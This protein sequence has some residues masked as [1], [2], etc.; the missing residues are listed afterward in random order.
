MKLIKRL[1]FLSIILFFLMGIGLLIFLETFDISRF[2]PQIVEQLNS[3]L[4][5]NVTLGDM[6]LSF[7]WSRGLNVGVK[8]L[9]IS[10]DPNFSDK[11]FLEVDSISLGIEI[12]PLITKRQIF[13]ASVDIE[14]PK[15]RLIRD[16]NGLL[17]AQTLGRQPQG[18]EA[19]SSL[20][21]FSAAVNAQA[22]SVGVS[23]GNVPTPS[24]SKNFSQ[25]SSQ[26]S[27][28]DFSI[29]SIR[30]RN[31]FLSYQ[32][33][34]VQPPISVDLPQM[35]VRIDRFT[36][37]KP[38]PV[39][40]KM[41]LWS[42]IPN[43]FVRGN[44]I[45][46]LKAGS[47]IYADQV[48]CT[49]DFSRILVEKIEQDL[50][51]VK[52]AG[53][54]NPLQGHLAIDIH[55]MKATQEGLID[56]AGDG[57]FSDGRIRLKPLAVPVEGIQLTFAFDE[58]DFIVNNFSLALGSGAV[59]GRFT[60]ED[61]LKEQGYEFKFLAEKVQIGE[62]I[63][64]KALPFKAV[65]KIEGRFEGKGQGFDPSKAL[66]SLTAGGQFNLFEGRLVDFNVLKFILEKITMIPNLVEKLERNLPDEYKAMLN[67]SD[68]IISNAQ[69]KT[70][71]YKG[72][73][74][75]PEAVVE[76]EGIKFSAQG[77]MTFEQKLKLNSSVVFE[78]SLSKAM[79]DSI[80][81]LKYF[82][83]D[84]NQI[85]IPLIPYDGEATKLVV[86]PDPEYLLK[87]FVKTK[88]RDELK[89]MIS[90]AMGREEDTAQ[91]PA[92]QDDQGNEEKSTEG[93]LLDNLL[94]SIF[95]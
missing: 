84:E 90:K 81:E 86:Y 30:I 20:E 24:D 40:F 15:I 62:I 7:S 91:Q 10:D 47:V 16:K 95:K 75:I 19:N 79:T 76:L 53:L 2:K 49:I 36:V 1:F 89:K 51:V 71:I 34:M 92:D 70:Q 59:S 56:L 58:K 87:K 28:P 46:E 63:G 74:H 72:S 73:V 33:T 69:L 61:Y 80:E 60:L 45:V 78:E 26:V 54:I 83:N 12:A 85:Y 9:K 39:D 25:Q 66:D 8:D 48:N 65:G 23:A 67:R 68:T 14:S 11:Y 6:K 88:G 43:V 50:P 94:D 27:L 3:L 5:R 82:L 21:V 18:K 13:I 38:F 42:L 31:G 64:Q 57:K 37:G 4:A 22:A 55:Q 44:V 41:A 32:D 52:S 93:K 77:A 35:D 17:N 29:N